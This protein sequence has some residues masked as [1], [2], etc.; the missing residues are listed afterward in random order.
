[1]G[2]SWYPLNE[3]HMDVLLLRSDAFGGV[4]IAATQA[5]NLS[6]LCFPLGHLRS[7]GRTCGS[8]FGTHVQR[9]LLLDGYGVFLFAASQVLNF[10]I[11]LVPSWS[12]QKQGYKTIFAKGALSG[13]FTGGCSEARVEGGYA[14]EEFSDVLLEVCAAG[15]LSFLTSHWSLHNLWLMTLNT[16]AKGA[17][18]GGYGGSLLAALKVLY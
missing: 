11:L 1:M 10:L 12:P 18:C 2:L 9:E 13:G 8:C 16:C 3:G 4:L 5:L 7:K 15:L 6:F 14:A 17:I